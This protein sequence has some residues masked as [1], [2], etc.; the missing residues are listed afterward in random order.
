MESNPSDR[1]GRRRE[2]S[3]ANA[4]L[5]ARLFY[6]GNLLAFLPGLVVAPFLFLTDPQK[7]MMIF[8]FLL[9]VVPPILWFGISIMVYIVARHHPNPRVGH[10]TQQAA[11]LFYGALG[12]IIPVGT[13][14]GTDWKLWIVTGG[15]V[16][17][18][19]VPWSALALWRIRR[20]D[21]QDTTY[22]AEH[23]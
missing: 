10:H 2:I 17:L 18:V 22:E 9:M 20:E 21:W 6:L 19:V 14:F 7:T 5:M 4:R 8:M 12:V 15:L 16:A 13:F 3:A 11:Y 1:S 23:P